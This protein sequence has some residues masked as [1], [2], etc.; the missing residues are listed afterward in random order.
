MTRCI[1]CFLTCLILACSPGCGGKPSVKQLRV[2]ASE[3][4]VEA[5]FQLAL[6]YANGDGIPA[7]IATAAGWYRKA[8]VQGH[9]GA[10]LALGR[11]LAQGTGVPKDISAALDWY[12]QA[13][14]RGLRPA[15]LELGTTL[16][17]G[18]GIPADPVTGLAWLKVAGAT[19][20]ELNGQ[21]LDTIE[22]GLSPEQ[23]T[24]SE[25]RFRE[26]SARAPKR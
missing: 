2:L 8:A 14:E 16:C 11:A 17:R 20:T 5:Q 21:S 13:A 26:F 24:E 25:K 7:D 4:D 6:H 9:S 23:R 3:G 18:A 22:A 1:L 15:Q 19:I 12:R 10:Q